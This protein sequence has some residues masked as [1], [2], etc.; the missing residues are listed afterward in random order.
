[1]ESEQQI[2][3]NSNE[4][5]GRQLEV[6]KVVSSINDQGLTYCRNNVF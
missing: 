4:V 6:D 2:Q 1:M 5:N 3:N